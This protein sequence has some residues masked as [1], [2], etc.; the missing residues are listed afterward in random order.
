MSTAAGL[1]E[2]DSR[3]VSNSREASKQLAGPPATAGRTHNLNIS[4]SRRDNR[5]I[6][7]VNSRRRTHN[8]RDARNNTVEMPTTVQ[9]SAGT[10][11]AKKSSEW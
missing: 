10:P 9:A 11:F 8:D 3:K 2:S 1:L 6:T 7:D 5:N 4:N